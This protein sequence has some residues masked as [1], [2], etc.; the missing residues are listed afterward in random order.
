MAVETRGILAAAAFCGFSGMRFASGSSSSP[1]NI[2][3]LGAQYRE[4]AHQRAT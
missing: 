2:L 1:H 3:I 4:S